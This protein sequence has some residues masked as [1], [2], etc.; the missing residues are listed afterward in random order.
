MCC[1]QELRPGAVKQKWLDTHIKA[2][3]IFI[4]PVQEDLVFTYSTFPSKLIDNK[5]DNTCGGYLGVE[6]FLD[7]K[8][9][10]IINVYNPH[11]SDVVPKS[12]DSI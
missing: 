11:N 5:T 4:I 9:I 10:T 1:F 8:I 2:D 6:I 7:S 3:L 12:P